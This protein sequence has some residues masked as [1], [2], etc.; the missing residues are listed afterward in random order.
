MRGTNEKESND[1]FIQEE[2]I[3][4]PIRPNYNFEYK[5]SPNRNIIT[6]EYDNLKN[7]K[8]IT[9][10]KASSSYQNLIKSYSKGRKRYNNIYEKKTRAIPSSY[11]QYTYLKNQENVN[12]YLKNKAYKKGLKLE[13]NKEYE[14]L[15][16]DEYINEIEDY[17]ENINKLIK[18]NDWYYIYPDENKNNMNKMKLTPLPSKSRLLM[19]T[20]KEKKDF[21]FAERN[22]VMMRRVEYTHSLITKDGKKEEKERL[23]KEREKIYLIMKNAV[24]RIENWWAKMLEKKKEKEDNFTIL[25]SNNK[26]RINNFF[27]YLDNIFH[28]KNKKEERKKIYIDFFRRLIKIRDED[29]KKNKL[30]NNF[31]VQNVHRDNQEPENLGSNHMVDI[32]K[33]EENLLKNSNNNTSSNYIDIKL[34][35]ILIKQIN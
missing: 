31:A 35:I 20:N 11:L 12:N 9:K 19:N 6:T 34:K 23:D 15:P 30:N 32:W 21:N 1:Y 28:F 22:A 5:D 13:G 16:I 14:N 4:S 24:L 17:R 2:L 8:I 26:E 25:L 7:K 10:S 27:I 3:P 18:H 29:N 33:S